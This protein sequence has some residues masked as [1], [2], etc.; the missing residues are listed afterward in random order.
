MTNV[1]ETFENFQNN[2]ETNYIS[3]TKDAT[4]RVSK[5]KGKYLDQA[6]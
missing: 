5:D 2:E 4:S 3:M 1:T 6:T